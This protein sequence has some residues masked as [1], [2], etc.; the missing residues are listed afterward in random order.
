[1]S[2]QERFEKW[3]MDRAKEAEKNGEQMF[4][5]VP[6]AWWEQGLHCCNNGHVN[7][8]YLKS[9]ELGGAVCFNCREKSQ[10][11]PTGLTEEEFKAEMQLL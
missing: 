3:I 9:E 6:E 8:S 10:I 2:R 5:Q 7:G 11:F 4:L 1:M